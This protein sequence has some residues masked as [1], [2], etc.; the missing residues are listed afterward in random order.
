MK[1]IFIWG[2]SPLLFLFYQTNEISGV[3]TYYFNDN[4]GN[5]P[6]IGATVYLIDSATHPEFK[7]WEYDS[8]KNIY[9]F[10]HL[11][12]L[13]NNE[14]TFSFPF[15]RKK[16]K[17]ELDSLKALSVECAAL[18]LSYSNKNPKT[19]NF[20]K[21]EFISASNAIINKQELFKTVDGAGN[22]TFR[23]IKPGVYYVL[24]ISKNRPPSY[25]GIEFY[26]RYIE[27]VEITNNDKTISCNFSISGD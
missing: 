7:Y 13:Y 22:Y 8:L 20:F 14:F 12:K 15:A 4:F 1:N 9:K 21:K 2:L 24:I 18:S 3:V 19:L 26:G 23:N 25:T 5:K 10:D 16:H 6:D 27:R 11:S 17:L